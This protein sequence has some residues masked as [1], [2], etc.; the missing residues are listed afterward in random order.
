[1][2]LFPSVLCLLLTAFQ[3][4]VAQSVQD[5]KHQQAREGLRARW[6]R[7]Q[8]S[9]HTSPTRRRRSTPTSAPLPCGGPAETDASNQPD[10]AE[11][12]DSTKTSW[13]GSC[14]HEG[15]DWFSRYLPHTSGRAVARNWRACR[16]LW[17]CHRT[18][19]GSKKGRPSNRPRRRDQGE[20]GRRRL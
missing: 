8:Y 18:V 5:C 12:S 1:M 19:R 14:A 20:L 10:R 16:H 3:N 13:N 11:L 6:R 4:S 9:P 7:L 17:P 2:R 15:D